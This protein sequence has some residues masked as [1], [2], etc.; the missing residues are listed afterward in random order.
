MLSISSDFL[1][2]LKIQYGNL[3][4]ISQSRIC[5]RMFVFSTVMEINSTSLSFLIY[6]LSPNT[7]KYFLLLCSSDYLLISV[8]CF[9]YSAK[10]ETFTL[11]SILDDSGEILLL[12]LPS[13]HL[14]LKLIFSKDFTSVLIKLNT[15]KAYGSNGI[16][17]LVLKA[18]A[19]KFT[20]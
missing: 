5:L 6:H 7:V 8:S 17:S 4:L 3:P 12:H 18:C 11:N 14:C 1:L 19:S 16:P 13:I 9:V 20:S 15:K 10:T 2:V